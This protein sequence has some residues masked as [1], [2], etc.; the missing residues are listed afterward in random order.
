[1]PRRPEALPD[2]WPPQKDRTSACSVTHAGICES[3]VHRLLSGCV[4]LP[5]SLQD[6]LFKRPHWELEPNGGATRTA[7]FGP[8]LACVCFHKTFADRQPES[9]SPGLSS[10]CRP[11]ELLEDVDQVTF[12]DTVTLIGDGQHNSVADAR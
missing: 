5:G 11:V 8:N 3:P 1:M 9:D 6:F 10:P 7:A 2:Q 4:R 12:G